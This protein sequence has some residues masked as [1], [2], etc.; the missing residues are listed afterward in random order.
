M[1][2]LS[3]Q[4]QKS[5]FSLVTKNSLSSRVKFNL[6]SPLCFRI[7]TSGS[8]LGFDLIG[9]TRQFLCSLLF[10]TV[11]REYVKDLLMVSRSPETHVRPEES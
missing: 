11:Q 4:V 10:I 7:L 3:C 8:G 9:H 2:L 5:G 6:I 1:K